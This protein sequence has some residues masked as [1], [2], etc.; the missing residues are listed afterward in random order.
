MK[1]YILSLLLSLLTTISIL[2]AQE[3]LDI[4]KATLEDLKKVPGIGEVT[5]K[6]IIEYREREGG[7]KSLEDLKK[8]KGI[9]EK[10]FEVLKN[11]LTVGEGVSSS[12]QGLPFNETMPKERQ[13]Y[14]YK[15]EKGVLHFTQFPEVVPEKYRKSLRVLR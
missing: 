8:V 6:S 2:F 4:N 9:G 1:R 11:Y 10:K 15:D 7:F 5:A 13:V 12:T 3:K 14:Y